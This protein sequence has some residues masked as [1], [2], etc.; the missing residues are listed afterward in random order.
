MASHRITDRGRNPF[1]SAHACAAPVARDL[2]ADTCACD[3]ARA[4]GFAGLPG[5]TSDKRASCSRATPLDGAS[6]GCA[7]TQSAV[8]HGRS[9][10]SAG[11]AP[12]DLGLGSCN[13]NHRARTARVGSPCVHS[14][15]NAPVSIGPA[16]DGALASELFS[17]YLAQDVFVERQI[18]Y[19][20]LQACVLIAQLPELTDLG[21][22]HLGVLLF[23]QVKARL[24]HTQLAADVR[25]RG[26]AFGL[27]QRIG[28][29][30]IG[31]SLALHGPLLPFLRT[32]EVSLVQF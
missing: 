12:T 8:S 17:D 19:Q 27:S 24:A 2:D 29:L 26:S 23:P 31:K 30:L 18:G 11:A 1:P 5:D 28:D 16:H 4:C 21:E 9:P 10:G 25:H 3:D 13:T 20:A 7:G 15:S 14:P 22:P 32:P 6:R